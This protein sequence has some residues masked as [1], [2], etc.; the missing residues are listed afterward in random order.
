MSL[1]L[2]LNSKRQRHRWKSHGVG[3]YYGTRN[4]PRLHGV[5]KVAS[6][7]CKTK[8][9]QDVWTQGLVPHI[10]TGTR[11]GRRLRRRTMSHE[12]SDHRLPSP[13]R[14]TTGFWSQNLPREIRTRIPYSERIEREGKEGYRRSETGHRHY[15]TTILWR[16]PWEYLGTPTLSKDGKWV[17]ISQKNK[18]ENARYYP[19]MDTGLPLFQTT[20]GDVGGGEAWGEGR[21]GGGDGR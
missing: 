7:R 4:D 21:R 13:K 9:T 19:E 11:K 14:C 6:T 10:G 3:D 20:D 1:P 5:Q 17:F 16:L 2:D 12:R 18:I 8:V 15:S